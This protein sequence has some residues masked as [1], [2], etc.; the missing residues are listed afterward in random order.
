MQ[1]VREGRR[2][3]GKYPENI[4]VRDFVLFMATPWLVYDAYPRR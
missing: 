1:C 2:A 4:N 3:E